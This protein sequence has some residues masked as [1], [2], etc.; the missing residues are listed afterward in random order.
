VQ[1]QPAAVFVPWKR[2]TQAGSFSSAQIGAKA[3]GLLS[4]PREWVPPFIVLTSEFH[5]LWLAKGS[6][7]SAFDALSPHDSAELTAFLEVAVKHRGDSERSLLVR[8]NAP[9]EDITARGSYSTFLSGA[10]LVSLSTAVERLL[11]APE[12]NA[13]MCPLIQLAIGP[14][15]PGHISNERR[16]SRTRQVWLIEGLSSDVGRSQ[17]EFIRASTRRST[18]ALQ[19]SSESEVRTALRRVAGF[20][21]TLDSQRRH[22]EW[23]WDG[24]RLWIVQADVARPPCH[25]A[26]ANSYLTGSHCGSAEPAALSTLTAFDERH[27]SRWSKLGRPALFR[28]IGMPAAE[29]F[30]LTGSEWV[31]AGAVGGKG[32]RQDLERL[33][34]HN[35]VVIRTDV[36]DAS[37]IEEVLLPTSPPIQSVERV[38]DSMEQIAGRLAGQG[39]AP[40]EWAFLLANLVPA[41][42]SA[43]VHAR[44]GARRVQVDSLW[45]FPDGLLHFPHDSSY[46]YPSS[47]EVESR[48]RYKGVCLLPEGEEWCARSVKK[49]LDWQAVLS[50]S[51]VAVLGEWGLATAEAVGS[52]VQLMCLARIAGE[53]GADALLPWHYT[54]WEVPGYSA[55]VL[56]LRGIVGLEVVA[57]WGDLE[58]LQSVEQRGDNRCEGYVAKPNAETIRDLEFLKAVGE[59]AARTRKPLY[60]EGSLLGHAYYVMARTGATVVPVAAREPEHHSEH[61]GKLVRDL[62]PVVIEKSGGLARVRKLERR[63]ALAVLTRK[64]VEEALEAY[65]SLPEDLAEELA[66]VLEVVDSIRNQLEVSA[67]ELEGI[68][69]RKRSRRGGFEELLF[70]EETSIRS[71]RESTDD[72]GGLPLFPEDEAHGA[73]APSLPERIV[74]VHH[75]D[76]LSGTMDFSLPLIPPI[77]DSA[78]RHRAFRVEVRGVILDIS[79]GSGRARVRV[80]RSTAPTP[81]NQTDLFDVPDHGG[82]NG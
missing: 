53:R 9:D 76:M 36:T 62:I 50:E 22:C 73:A 60:F 10:D 54:S 82:R 67:T 11:A 43:M 70:L 12:D 37:G 47:G 8:S 79:Y 75:A 61:Y 3:L 27:S 58:S 80:S 35:P 41:V 2:P 81:G 17:G 39:V 68:R 38:V 63:S 13:R 40:Q 57:S 6:V 55:G 72:L 26:S 15:W 4:L 23:V 42:A 59:L 45:G 71:L 28:R 49:P 52:E 25:L 29:I 66:D 51:E 56:S 64:L 46:Y 69:T 24:R 78:V 14:S 16:L 5:S 33:C 1:S 19:A 21:L 65:E 18:G 48:T 74:E 77:V 44:P 31:S 7:R 30:I 34:S 32:L 20:L